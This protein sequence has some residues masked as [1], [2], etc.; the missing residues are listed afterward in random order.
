MKTKCPPDISSR[1][2]SIT[3]DRQMKADAALIYEAWTEKFD[4]WF[5]EP[6]DLIMVP[7]IDRPW[8]FKNRKDWGSHPHYGR[9]VELEQNRLVVT[10]WLT[11]KGGT[12]GAETIIRIELTSADGA[13]LLRLTHSGFPDEASQKG[14]LDNWPEALE[15]LDAAL[16]K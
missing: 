13:T 10:T 5:A 3:V 4:C 11:G 9:F 1:P 14:H 15:C 8:F 7:E 12:E 2:L 16:C 6:G